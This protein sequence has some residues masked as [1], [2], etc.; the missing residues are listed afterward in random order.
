MT[1]PELLN[2]I[3]VLLNTCDKT[4]V[5]AFYTAVRKMLSS[6]EKMNKNLEWW[7]KI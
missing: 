1:K 7:C 3:N 4:T 6:G 2:S 5:E